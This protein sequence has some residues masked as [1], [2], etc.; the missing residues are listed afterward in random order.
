[1]ARYILNR[2]ALIVPIILGVT[3]IIFLILAFIP[4]DPAQLMLGE[5]ASAEAVAALRTELGLDKPLLIRYGIFLKQLLQGD[6]GTS[7]L[8]R[9]PV[10]KLIVDRLPAT[11]ELTLF[12]MFVGSVIGVV[13]GIISATKQHSL[14]DYTAMFISILGVSMPVFWLGIML[15]LFFSVNLGW[16]PVSGRGP[17]V[18]AALPAILNGDF[19]PLIQGL[20]HILL[21]SI[22]LGTGL[23]ALIARMTRSSMLEIIRQDYVKTAKAKGLPGKLVIWKH[24]LK[25]A[26]I[27][28]ITALGLQFGQLLGGA[29][30]TESIF[31]WPGLGRLAVDAINAR[32]FPVIQGVVLVI[33]LG[34]VLVNLIVDLIYTF[35]DPRIRYS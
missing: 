25:N 34:V 17:G 2:L 31:A 13:A 16:L 7:Y 22:T 18:I 28:V 9:A 11:L 1:L 4:G 26:L 12:A 21:P 24:A 15:I 29:V 27:P 10:L 8:Q 19:D 33:T 32:D 20:R 5:A 23:A 30:L 14:L 6:L 3:L 35:I